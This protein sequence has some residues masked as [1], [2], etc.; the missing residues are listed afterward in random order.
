MLC[1]VINKCEMKCSLGISGRNF[2]QYRKLIVDMGEVWCG[3]VMF[4]VV[5]YGMVWY[6]VMCYLA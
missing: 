4:G 6:G 5:W 1:A 3:V 2:R